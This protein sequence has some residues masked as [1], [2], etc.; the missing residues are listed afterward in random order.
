MHKNQAQELS[1]LTEIFAFYDR[2]VI[3]SQYSKKPGLYKS[4]QISYNRTME[5][6]PEPPTRYRDQRRGRV[7]AAGREEYTT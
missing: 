5:K 2:N 7:K 1:V 4:G 6:A 3:E